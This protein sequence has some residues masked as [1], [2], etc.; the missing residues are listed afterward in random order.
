MVNVYASGASD[1]T[2]IRDIKIVGGDT[3]VFNYANVN[4]E[5]LF[6]GL[7]DNYEVN[8]ESDANGCRWKR[9]RFKKRKVTLTLREIKDFT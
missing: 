4:D 6:S 7:Y 2:N 8:N 3:S 1:D 9:S 5:E